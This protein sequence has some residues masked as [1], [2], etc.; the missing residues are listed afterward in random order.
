MSLQRFCRKEIITAAADDAVI[1]V[2]RLM[3]D[4]HVGAVVIVDD[5]GLPIGIVTDRDLAV[6]VLAEARDISVPVRTIMTK[7]PVSVDTTAQL[8]DAINLMRH[9]GVR[10]VPIVDATGALAGL[11]SLDDINVLLAAELGASAATVRDNR[12]P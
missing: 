3:R 10:R 4:C 8:D 2:A 7:N 5:E 9:S 1:H 11:V 12:G 6:R